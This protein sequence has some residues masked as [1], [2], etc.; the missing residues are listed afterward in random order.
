MKK[1]EKKIRQSISRNGFIGFIIMMLFFFIMEFVVGGS[2]PVP[3]E[4]EEGF[5][6][7]PWMK[8]I[9]Y[10][11]GM[12]IVVIVGV[13][14]PEMSKFMQTVRDALE[15][16]RITAEEA[17]AMLRQGWF[18]FQG[19]W[20]DVSQIA[21]KEEKAKVKKDTELPPKEA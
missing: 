6:I 1:S 5:Q 20:A 15:D 21:N 14:K 10:V 8:F 13:D 16:G 7:L 3:I 19:F 17:M 11:T 4:G 9:L 12:G 18:V 2:V